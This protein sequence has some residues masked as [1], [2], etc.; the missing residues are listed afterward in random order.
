MPNLRLHH[1][2]NRNSEHKPR[3]IDRIHTSPI[4]NR[5]ENKKSRSLSN[6]LII[7]R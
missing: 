5:S 3:K 2:L 1:L 7:L 6:K 4:K